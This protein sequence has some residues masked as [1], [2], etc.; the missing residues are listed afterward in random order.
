[1]PGTG[2]ASTALAFEFDQ[3]ERVADAIVHAI[4]LALAAGGATA[5][6]V[7]SS[8]FTSWPTIASAAVY[9]TTLMAALTISALYNMWPA[10]PT[11]WL[12]RRFDQAAIFLLIGGTYTA[13]MT[14]SADYRI[15][16][17]AL[18]AVWT[19][20][21]IGS[22]AKLALPGRFERLSIFAY[23]GLG[24]S[25]LLL[26]PTAAE[27]LP[28]TALALIALGG[29]LYSVGVIFFLWERLRFHN[30]IWHALVLAAA[31]CHYGAVVDCLVITR[32]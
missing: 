12:L 32:A 14:R 19:I 2:Q 24:W 23:L 13:F 11:K 15:S 6:M 8:R 27:I 30:A 4:G 17:L 7:L 16:L 31:I 18:G 29:L 10:S 20:A 26:F 25:G 1:M 21:T 3:V 5:L 9:V 28:R 22:V